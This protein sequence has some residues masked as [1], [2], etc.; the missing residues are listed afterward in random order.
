MVDRGGNGSK[1]QCYKKHGDGSVSEVAP[2]TSKRH[3]SS[4][5]KGRERP[6]ETQPVLH[7]TWPRCAALRCA[8]Q[9]VRVCNMLEGGITPLASYQELRDIGFH[10]VL[11]PLTG[12]LG[13]AGGAP[14]GRGLG[15]AHGT[16]AAPARRAACS[17]PA[18]AQ[19]QPA[20]AA[21]P[22]L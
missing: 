4:R 1:P 9:G 5:G 2:R 17:V 14:R 19:L 22:S 21:A 16:R 18:A 7:A 6:S 11:H 10:V 8:A 20:Q 13:G 12:R 15:P 3:S